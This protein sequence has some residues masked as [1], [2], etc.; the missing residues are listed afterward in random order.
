MTAREKAKERKK[1]NCSSAF[2][3]WGKKSHLFFGPEQRLIPS[4]TAGAA[5][6]LPSTAKQI[7]RE[8]KTSKPL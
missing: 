3:F 2:I 6:V 8:K 4:L 5:A 1:I 7:E